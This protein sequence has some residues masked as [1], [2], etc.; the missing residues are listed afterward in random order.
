[1]EAS[2]SRARDGLSPSQAGKIYPLT[3]PEA[4]TMT[5]VGEKLSTATGRTI[6]YVNIPPEEAT[7]A[8]FRG[9]QPAPKV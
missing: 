4:L 2:C 8:I 5:E 3:G 9:E 6:S 1:M 7:R